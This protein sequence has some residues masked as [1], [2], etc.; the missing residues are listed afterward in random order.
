MVIDSTIK[1]PVYLERFGSVSSIKW[2]PPLDG[3]YKFNVD[4]AY[5]KRNSNSACGGLLRD[6]RGNLI[7]GFYCKIGA[8]N[9]KCAEMWSLVYAVRMTHQ[10]QID[11]SYF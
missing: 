1:P 7:Q 2:E 9:S 4:D 8:S 11:Q 5:N 6:V 10:L 3:K